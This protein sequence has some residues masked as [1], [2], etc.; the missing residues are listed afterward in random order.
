MSA[1]FEEIP[2]G[3]VEGDEV[4]VSVVVNSTF[5]EEI[6]TSY[7]WEITNKNGDKINTKF[8]GSVSNRQGKVTIPAGGETLFY[9]SFAMPNSDVRIQFKS[10]V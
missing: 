5:E 8:L 9:A 7:E 2:S 4:L 3:A 10:F 6:T 1:N